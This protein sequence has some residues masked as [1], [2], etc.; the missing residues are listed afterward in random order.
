M[1]WNALNYAKYV[2]GYGSEKDKNKF[3]LFAFEKSFTNNEDILSIKAYYVD[4][5]KLSGL[6]AKLPDDLKDGDV[7]K[8]VSR[9]SDKAVQWFLSICVEKD[10]MKETDTIKKEYKL[11][12]RRIC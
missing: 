12:I 11:K 8:D 9:V 10:K 3:E 2:I 4:L 7:L 1:L 5:D 6:M